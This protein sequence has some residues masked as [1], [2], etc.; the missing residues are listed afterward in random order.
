M[1]NCVRA[2]VRTCVRVC[3]CVCVCVRVDSRACNYVIIHTE[4]FIAVMFNNTDEMEVKKMKNDNILCST[5]L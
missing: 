3:V 4:Q 1:Y 5:L 2:C